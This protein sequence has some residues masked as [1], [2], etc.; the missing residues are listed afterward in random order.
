M[1]KRIGKPEAIAILCVLA[2]GAAMFWPLMPTFLAKLQG[3]AE[4]ALGI[5]ESCRGV[6]LELDGRPINVDDKGYTYL[7]EGEGEHTLAE[8]D[9]GQIRRLKIR[10]RTSD[11][12]ISIRCRPLALKE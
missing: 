9:E 1:K 10:V 7:Y 11:N 12:Y 5:D 2:V 6:R 3:K 8:I 4:I